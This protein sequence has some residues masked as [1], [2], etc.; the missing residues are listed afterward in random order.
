MEQKIYV[1]KDEHGN[2]VKEILG[3]V[4]IL[5]PMLIE[6]IMHFNDDDNF[7]RIIAAELAIAQ[8]IK[9]DPIMGRVTGDEDP[10]LKS[11]FSPNKNN[12]LFTQSR[13]LFP[14]KRKNKL[15]S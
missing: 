7:D 8:A 4:R 14:Q 6:E 10:R 3:I 12:V 11:Y 1:D 5:D 2:V 9:M 13:G 15:F